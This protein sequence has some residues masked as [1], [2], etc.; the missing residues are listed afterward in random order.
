M[1]TPITPPTD[2]EREE[3]TLWIQATFRM[4]ATQPDRLEAMKEELDHMADQL[5]DFQM[6][7]IGPPIH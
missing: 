2:Q 5:F 3:W 6:Q 7:N 1:E 4:L